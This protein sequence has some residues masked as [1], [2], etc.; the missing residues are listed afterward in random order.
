MAAGFSSFTQ[1]YQTLA[2][3]ANLMSTYGGTVDEFADFLGPIFNSSGYLGKD[4]AGLEWQF[5]SSISTHSRRRA[6]Y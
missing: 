6:D 1:A 3:C 4:L 2:N 5:V